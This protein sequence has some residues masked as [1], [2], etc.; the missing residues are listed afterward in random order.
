M[1]TAGGSK[2]SS[3]LTSLI[4]GCLVL[5]IV[6][7]YICNQLAPN[8][9]MART[10]AGYFSIITDVFL[11]LIKMIIAPLVFSTLVAG[12][13]SLNDTAAVGRIALKALGWFITA[14]LVSL[15]LGMLFANILAPGSNLA[16]PLPEAGTSTNLQAATL[17]LKDFITHVFPTSAVLAMAQNEILQI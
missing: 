8:A 7:G 11:R 14:S 2:K 16:L 9:E 4:M 3:K 13:A 5:G 10:I 12:I 17:N 1:K 15:A 6:V